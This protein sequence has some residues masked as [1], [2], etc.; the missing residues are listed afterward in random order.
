MKFLLLVLLV[1]LS[2]AVQ[3]GPGEVYTACRKDCPHTCADVIQGSGPKL[4]VHTCKEGC[5]C[6]KGYALNRGRCIPE[7]QCKVGSVDWDSSKDA[8]A[9]PDCPKNMEYSQC[10]SVCPDPNCST[11]RH[12]L[13][14]S[15]RCG[16]PSCR[17]KS[18]YVR[19]NDNFNDGCINV[20]TCPKNPLDTVF[21]QFAEE[22]AAASRRK[23]SKESVER[24]LKYATENGPQDPRCPKNSYWR[25]CSNICKQ[26]CGNYDKNFCHSLRCGPPKCECKI[27]HY[28]GGPQGKD[29]VHVNECKKQKA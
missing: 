27:N 5:I 20:N 3:C 8:P 16:P 2:Y 26:T 21:Q 11:Y 23:R 12:N 14:F 10:G 15:N 6:K 22:D 18:G 7:E 28:L 29:C 25:E 24:E 4:C 17:C 13:C 19:K 9:V 1:P